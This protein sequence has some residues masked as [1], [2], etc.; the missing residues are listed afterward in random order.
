M[1]R[2]TAGRSAPPPP[3]GRLETGGRTRGP[4]PP[5]SG[6]CAVDCS[7]CRRGSRCALPPRPRRPAGCA[8][9][10]GTR[11]VSEAPEAPASP[12]TPTAVTMRAKPAVALLERRR[13][14]LGSRR[15]GGRC[16]GAG[17][18][19]GPRLGRGQGRT[20]GATRTGGHASASRACGT[21][22]CRQQSRE[23][24]RRGFGSRAG[25]G[26]SAHWRQT[27]CS[28]LPR[29][30]RWPP[31]AH[32]GPRSTPAAGRCGQRRERSRCGDPRALP[33]GPGRRAA[34]REWT[35]ARLRAALMP[36]QRREA[37]PRLMPRLR[38]CLQV[39]FR[40][41]SDSAARTRG[42]TQWPTA[43]GTT[44]VRGPASRSRRPAQSPRPAVRF[45]SLA[46]SPPRRAGHDHPRG[47]R[48]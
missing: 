26:L 45:P 37:S 18:G 3:P 35:R 31:K 23:L 12:P 2:G 7:A 21:Q 36:R 15:G 44:A 41:A 14:R 48:P 39:S 16:R 11:A 46:A 4:C 10:R 24:R 47:D 25:A 28:R 20:C 17:S 32:R 33:H 19:C 22:G 40:I 29:A 30:Q 43:G 34:T 13:R 6:R 42:A 9:G 5:R 27:R 1:P 8:S 38:H